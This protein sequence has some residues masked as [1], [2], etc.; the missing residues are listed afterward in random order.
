VSKVLEEETRAAVMRLFSEAEFVASMGI[1]AVAL[2]VG[3]C[4]ARLQIEPRHLQHLGRVHGG[5]VTTLAGHAALGAAATVCG[6]DEPLVA[7]DFSLRLLRGVDSGELIAEAKV[8]KRGRALVFVDVEVF[9]ADQLVANASY[10]LM[11]PAPIS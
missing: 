5:V 3:F 9:A 11:R 8:L 7:P 10:T 4:R 2:E 6:V 1:K